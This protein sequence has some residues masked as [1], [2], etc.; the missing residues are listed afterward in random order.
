MELKRT[1]AGG[2]VELL[3]SELPST[4]V[5]VHDRG[6]VEV[7]VREKVTAINAVL[8]PWGRIEGSLRWGDQPGAGEVITL[9]SLRPGDKPYVNH[10][11]EALTDAQGWFRFG[12]VAPG[13]CQ[14]SRFV[15]D[16]LAASAHVTAEPG[17]AARATLGGRGLA[18]IGRV[19][20]PAEIAT[21]AGDRP[22]IDI[23]VFL[24]PPPI[25][26]PVDRV[27]EYNRK[28]DAFL[29]SEHG[30]LYV[31][32]HVPVGPDGRFRVEG[33]PPQCYVVQVRV[34]KA[35]R[36]EESLSDLAGFIASPFEVPP[37]ENALS[38]SLVDLGALQPRSIN[39]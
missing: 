34:P 38:Q 24:R 23:R 26:G 15:D 30:K 1:G 39:D 3:V 20:L 22:R 10:H 16:F 27:E 6:Y 12:R 25:S 28:Y 21:P 29:A 37:A 11:Q 13:Q 35:G 14:M 36:R 19:V 4:L 32:E 8:R 33:L 17:A 5:A 31:H 18:L 7:P 9:F 2:R